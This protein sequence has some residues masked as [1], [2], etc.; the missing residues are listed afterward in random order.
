MITSRVKYFLAVWRKKSF[1]KAAASCGVSQPSLTT[2]IKTLENALGGPLFHRHPQ[3][4]LTD[5][6]KR[7]L[8]QMRRLERAASQAAIIATPSGPSA[9]VPAQ[10]RLAKEGDGS[11]R[12]TTLVSRRIAK[13]SARS[14][15]GPPNSPHGIDH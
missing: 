9:P 5:L 1:R 10:L 3:V 7:L 14:A 12:Q 4:A 8:P 6:G 15:T 13:S 11:P 2:G